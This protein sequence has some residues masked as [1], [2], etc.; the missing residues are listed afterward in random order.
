MAI[1]IKVATT[2]KELNDV[3]RLRYQ[4][5][6]ET[7]GCFKDIKGNLII[8][9]FD[10]MPKVANII[11]YEGHIPVGTIRVNLDSEILLPADEAYDFSG[12]RQSV[13]NTSKN[14]EQ[15]APIFV[16]AGMLAIAEQWRNRRDV[17]RVLFKLACDV[18]HSWQG[19]HVI[20]TASIKSFSIYKRLGFVAL[21]EKVWYEPAGEYIVPMASDS[22]RVYKWAFSG[23][24]GQSELLENFTGCFQYLIYSAGSLIFSEGEQGDEAYLISRGTVNISRKGHES[25][26]SLNLA[27]LGCGDLFGELSII[28][29]QPR[30]ADT[31]AISNTELIVL[32]RKVFWQ[33]AHED[34]EYL[35]SLLSILSQRIRHIDDRAYVY[36]HGS[37]SQRL[38]FFLAAIKKDAIPSAKVHNQ[39]VSKVTVEE[40]SFM[41]SV[42]QEE[43]Q[44]FLQK[45]QL[46]QKI[47]MTDK[48]IVFYGE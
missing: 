3:Y 25:G 32:S 17:F 41:A 29:E 27:T 36:A 30:S 48:S 31:T 15:P 46:E 24:E 40:F 6:V 14:K 35:R 5:Y 44:N 23:L 12:Y 22:A 9:Q 11:A 1:R 39:R 20:V 2:A 37:V 21:E 10:A 28:D 4:V 13:A 33:K 18:A 19:S 16:N 26:N 47:E 8:D 34:P 43:A 7:E 45:Q 38:N 42:A